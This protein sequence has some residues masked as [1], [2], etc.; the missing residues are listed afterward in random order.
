MAADIVL[1]ILIN[2]IFLGGIYAMAGIGL[3]LIWGV[4]NFMNF[5]TGQMVMTGMYVTLIAAVWFGLDPLLG[6]VFAVLVLGAMGLFIEKFIVERLINAP[7]VM[8]QIVVT[9]SIGL[10]LENIFYTVFG[11]ELVN[12]PNKLGSMNILTQTVQLSIFRLTPARMLSLPAAIALTILLHLFLT[13]T[14]VGLAVRAVSQNMS[15]GKLMGINVKRI[16]FLAWG[17]GVSF[18]GLAGGLLMLTQAAYP[19]VGAPFGLV[20]MF[21]VTLGG[22]GSYLGTF[23]SAMLVASIES[24]GGYYLGTA[25]KQILYLVMFIAVLLFRPRGLIP[26]K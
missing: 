8:Y 12:I 23:I 15:A 13:R 17:L 18:M 6:I 2:G 26:T 14:R 9:L 20:A 5:A 3:T 21:I 4:M 16:F 7:S 25:I 24:V 10:I 1:Q 19:Q 11:V 22:S